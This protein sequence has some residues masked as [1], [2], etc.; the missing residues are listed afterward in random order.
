MKEK[1]KNEE[2]EKKKKKNTVNDT[3]VHSG[4]EPGSSDSLYPEQWASPDVEILQGKG[5]DGRGCVL[6]DNT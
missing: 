4:D 1:K 5:G 2:E 3:R 6:H